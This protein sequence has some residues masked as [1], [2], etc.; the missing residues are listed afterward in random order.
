MLVKT[1]W[2]CA[3][4]A[5]FWL[6]SGSAM[7]GWKTM[8]NGYG[9]FISEKSGKLY[10]DM[11]NSQCLSMIVIPHPYRDGMKAALRV[12]KRKIRYYKVR[13]SNN[14][15]NS[16][17]IPDPGNLIDNMEFGDRLYLDLLNKEG[18]A[19]FSRRY[20]LD[21]FKASWEKAMAACLNYYRNK[22][23]TF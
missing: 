15:S 13:P 1:G 6:I 7:A 9:V 23:P 16:V 18:K 20:S 17:T 8:S 4:V 19:V 10:V 11:N 12:D 21:R 2:P 3:L 22:Q 5:A 14:Y